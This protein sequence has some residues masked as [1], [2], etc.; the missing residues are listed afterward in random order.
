MKRTVAMIAV[1]ATFWGCGKNPPEK[2]ALDSNLAAALTQP[3]KVT[4]LTL[5]PTSDVATLPAELWTLTNLRELNLSC[6]EAL[7]KL[8]SEIERLRMLEKLILDCGNGGSMNISLPEE[9]GNLK[10]LTVLRLYVQWIPAKAVRVVLDAPDSEDCPKPSG[11]L[12]D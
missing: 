1:V 4:S 3:G 12:L 8:P 11:C 5:N 7:E 6:Q 10:H 2:P 9:I